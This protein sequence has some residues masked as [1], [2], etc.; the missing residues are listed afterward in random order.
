MSFNSSNNVDFNYLDA[1]SGKNTQTQVS[2]NDPHITSSVG[3]LSGSQISMNNFFGTFSGTQQGSKIVASTNTGV[4]NQ[5]QS[6][7]ISG[8]GQTMAI[9]APSDGSG[10]GAVY[11]YKRSGSTWSYQTKLIDTTSSSAKSQGSCVSLSRDGTTLAV[12]N[13]NYGIS[14]WNYSASTWTLQ[15]STYATSTY[16]GKSGSGVCISDDGNTAILSVAQYSLGS[17]PGGCLVYT[18]SGSTW[19]QS[20]YIQPADWQ[21]SGYGNECQVVGMSGD[22]TVIAFGGYAGSGGGSGWIYTHSG[23]TWT[24]N[25]HNYIPSTTYFGLS[26]S[27]SKS[28]NTIAFG[29]NGLVYI[30]ALSNGTWSLQQTLSNNNGG[31][32][33]ASFGCSVA[34]SGDGNSLVVGASSDSNGTVGAAYYFTRSGTTWTQIYRFVPSDNVGNSD[35]GSYGGGAASSGVAITPD[36]NTVVVGG[37]GDNTNAGATWV[38]Q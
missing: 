28:G 34:L 32:S 20:A 7:A 23:G 31:G 5:G 6:V 8:D 16:Y 26:V 4:G 9:G 13:Y 15:Q 18:R 22:A 2:L 25:F 27:V 37:Y 10:K 24:E 33:T 11:I 3:I 14:L 29:A 36:G 19:S 35:F 38:F 1:V 21:G 17:T 30:Y 12:G